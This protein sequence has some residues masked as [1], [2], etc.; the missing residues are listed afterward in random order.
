M[1]E[2]SIAWNITCGAAAQHDLTTLD[3]HQRPRFGNNHD[4]GIVEPST[5]KH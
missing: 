2:A 1:G 3:P 4:S 5:L